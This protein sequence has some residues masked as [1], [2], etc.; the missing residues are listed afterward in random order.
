M[1]AFIPTPSD[2]QII[3]KLNFLFSKVGK[4]GDLKSFTDRNGK[5]I[6]PATHLSRAARRIGAYPD[7]TNDAHGRNPRARWYVFLE[8]LPQATKNDINDALVAAIDPINGYDGVI[9][10]LTHEPTGTDPYV[11]HGGAGTPGEVV[12]LPDG[13]IVLLLTLVCDAPIPTGGGNDRP[14][15]P[16]DP[17]GNSGNERDFW[18]ANAPW[19]KDDTDY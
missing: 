4:L 7:S 2:Q 11:V 15:S 12:R 14:H 19:K 9:F 6:F 13:Q 17:G 5:K 18:P 1:G 3:A 8:K 16:H 10:N